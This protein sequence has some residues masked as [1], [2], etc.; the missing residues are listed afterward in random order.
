MTDEVMEQTIN[1]PMAFTPMASNSDF[2]KLVTFAQSWGE[3]KI[4]L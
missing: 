3:V 2:T 1:Y 4:S